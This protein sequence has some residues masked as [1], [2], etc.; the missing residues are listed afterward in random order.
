MKVWVKILIAVVILVVLAW[1][2][3]FIFD[4]SISG[5][6]ILGESSMEDF[7]SC[8]SDKE[9]VLFGFNGNPQVEAQLVLFENYSSSVSYVDCRINPESCV[10]VIVHPSWKIEGRIVSSGLSLRMLSQLS[11]CG[12]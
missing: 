1:G 4:S 12:L 11:G 2:L 10:G 3:M 5:N 8:L 7:V 9:I 6:V